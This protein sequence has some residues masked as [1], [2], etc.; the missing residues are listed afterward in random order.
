MLTEFDRRAAAGVDPATLEK[1]EIVDGTYRYM[2]ALPT[3]PMCLAC[4]G[5]ADEIP[6]DVG[7]RLRE[8]YPG[9]R[10]VGYE[11]GQVRGAIT[12]R[13]ALD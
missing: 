9:D 6:A 5:G 3:Q 7:A 13:R 10:A 1:A 11:V 4:H 2:K 8:L 12:V